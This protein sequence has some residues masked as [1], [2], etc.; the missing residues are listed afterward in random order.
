[1]KKKFFPK[2][3]KQEVSNSLK[4]DS[5]HNWAYNSSKTN[6]GAENT[7][8]NTTEGPCFHVAHILEWRETGN[9][10]ESM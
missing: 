7:M 8:V 10:Y 1:M 5:V 9:S 3:Y 4:F 2:F 6:L